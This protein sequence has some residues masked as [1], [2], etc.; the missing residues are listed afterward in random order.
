MSTRAKIEL[1]SCPSKGSRLARVLET[2]SAMPAARTGL[3]AYAQI[4]N[5]LNLLEDQVWSERHFWM[6]RTYEGGVVTDRLYVSHPESFES[7]DGFEGVVN[8]VHTKEFIFISRTGGIEIQKDTG[9][10][11]R[12]VHFETRTHAVLFSKSDAQGR[13]VWDESHRDPKKQVATVARAFVTDANLAVDAHGW[14]SSVVM[15]P[16]TASC[17]ET[18]CGQRVELDSTGKT[19]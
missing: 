8:M 18:G 7:V 2:V 4:S 19:L 3:E 10:C 15:S 1:S 14:G 12:S 13:S 5:A 17:A 6:P 11:E 16:A 9:E